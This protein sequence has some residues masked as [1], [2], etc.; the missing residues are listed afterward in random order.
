[1]LPRRENRRHSK[2]S[3]NNWINF[4]TYPCLV[5]GFGS[6]PAL[7]VRSQVEGMNCAHGVRTQ[8]ALHSNGVEGVV[9][10]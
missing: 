8:P 2:K 9:N 1:M 5:V 6:V 10:R 3:S 7:G 4:I